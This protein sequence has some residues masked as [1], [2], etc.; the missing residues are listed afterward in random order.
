MSF[1][2]ES[3]REFKIYAG[4]MS[5]TAELLEL[6]VREF[7]E[8]AT[9]SGDCARFLSV[10]AKKYGRHI[11][12]NKFPDLVRRTIH[13]HIASLHE[14]FDRFLRAFRVD[15]IKMFGKQWRDFDRKSIL[16][17]T[18]LNIF[19]SEKAAR[20]QIGEMQLELCD[21]YRLIRNHAMHPDDSS[22]DVENKYNSVQIFKG[23]VLSTYDKIDRAPNSFNVVELDDVSLFI[24]AAQDV[25][26]EL[27]QNA[28][29]DDGQLL[30]SIESDVTKFKIKWRDLNR[31]R[32]AVQ[33]LLTKKFGL[34][35]NESARLANTVR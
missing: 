5:A 1:R 12:L 3:F 9:Q 8:S 21:Y 17:T 32:K 4:K 6:A 22:D 20:Q 13:Y 2:Y 11:N 35:I 30:H 27:C 24:R 23:K 16:Q 10:I 14:S 15:H 33:N 18:I 34:D 19:P 26:W 29:P 7:Q 25:A 28:K 31:V